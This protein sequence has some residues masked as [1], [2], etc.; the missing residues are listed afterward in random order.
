MNCDIRILFVEDEPLDVQLASLELER[1]GI[2]FAACTVTNEADLST[3]LDRF[4]P[5]VV[6][7]DYCIPGFSGVQALDV[8]R[9]LRPSTPILMFSGTIAE[10]TAIECLRHGATDYLLKSNPR[11]LGPAV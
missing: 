7:C 11:R 2:D 4:N 3:E 8:V 10:D 5:D 6:L 1:E 9:L